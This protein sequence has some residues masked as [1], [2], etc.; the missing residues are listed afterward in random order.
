MERTVD[1]LLTSAEVCKMFNV[2]PMTLY[3]WRQRKDFP[4][5]T[6]R[7]TTTDAIRFNRDDVVTW[8]QNTGHDVVWMPE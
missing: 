7:G 5:V 6:I 3:N 4:F 2:T 1:D 8:A